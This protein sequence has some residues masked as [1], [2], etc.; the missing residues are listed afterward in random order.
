MNRLRRR[1]LEKIAQTTTTDES[2]TPAQGAPATT[3]TPSAAPGPNSNPS[4]KARELN[5]Y[6]TTGWRTYAQNIDAIVTLMD[7]AII[8][9]TN[10]QQNFKSLYLTKFQSGTTGFDQIVLNIIALG[11]EMFAQYLNNSNPFEQPLQNNDMKQRAGIIN[12]SANLAALTRINPASPLGLSG[13][14]YTSLRDAINGLFTT[15]PSQ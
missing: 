3:T 7:K 5:T 12:N 2:A 15:I 13:V 14:T 1:I 11:R 6:L 4:P 9:G 8:A 10:G